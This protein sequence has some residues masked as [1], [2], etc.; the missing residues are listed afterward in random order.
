MER[1]IS[2]TKHE[3]AILPG[4]RHRMNQAESTEDIKKFFAYAAEELV[5]NCVEED[6]DWHYEDI[7]LDPEAGEGYAVAGRLMESPAFASVFA[8]SDLP[9]ILGR[10]AAT[11]VN[12]FKHLEKNPAKTN[13][14]MYP[15]PD[16]VSR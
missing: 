3:N 14:K 1:H 12:D 4:F 6:L 13:S 8:S 15:I 7:R 5:K 2:F 9:H 16:R 10:L 11:A